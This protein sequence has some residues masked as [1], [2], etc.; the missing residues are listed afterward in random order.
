MKWELAPRK[1]TKFLCQCNYTYNA[2]K[3]V[4]ALAQVA[5]YFTVFRFLSSFDV[6]RCDESGSPHRRILAHSSSS[7]PLHSTCVMDFR[8]FPVSGTHASSHMLVSALRNG[9][10]NVI[11]LR[12]APL[13]ASTDMAAANLQVKIHKPQQRVDMASLASASN[14]SNPPSSLQLSA[15]GHQLYLFTE[16]GT[17]ECWD[18]RLM[19]AS[20][21]RVMLLETLWKDSNHT[22][23]ATG[24]ASTSLLPPPSLGLH[25]RNAWSRVCSSS[26]HPQDDSTFL[27]QLTSGAVG[28]VDLNPHS[29]AFKRCDTV[30]PFE[31]DFITAS[32]LDDFSLRARH[33]ATFLP[34]G[35]IGSAAGAAREKCMAVANMQQEIQFIESCNKRSCAELQTQYADSRIHQIFTSAASDP[36]VQRELHRSSD[37][38]ALSSSSRL[39]TLCTIPAA[40]THVN[41]DIAS[42]QQSNPV[43][44]LA[45][46]PTVPILLAGYKQQRI[47]LITHESELER[48]LEGVLE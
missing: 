27:F 46:H 43:M 41:P 16:N 2:L 40:S 4:W 34:N 39:H 3:F 31:P 35:Q 7:A 47:R 29:P 1:I 26:I 20:F 19:R 15:C 30:V 32:S 45:V 24:S 14:V 10:V 12:V 21:D 22:L 38:S 44:S 9:E 36:L 25:L 13:A 37:R 48:H 18:T 17:L 28:L 5:V 11:D 42:I 33:V 8:Y 23:S 6:S